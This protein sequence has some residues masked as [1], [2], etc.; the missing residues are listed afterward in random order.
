MIQLFSGI[1]ATLLLGVFIIMCLWKPIYLDRLIC[2]WHFRKLL[3]LVP[4]IVSVP[5]ALSLLSQIIGI[6]ASEMMGDG[7]AD[8]DRVGNA[9]VVVYHYLNS[10]FMPSASTDAGRWWALI[11]ALLGTVFMSGIL[12]SVLTSIFDT[13]IEAWKNGELRYHRG[14][15]DHIVIVGGNEL[16][17]PVIKQTFTKYNGEQYPH[18]WQILQRPLIIVQTDGDVEELRKT[19][20]KELPSIIENCITIYSGGRS[21][22]EE[23]ADLCL[24]KA[25]EIFVLG[26]STMRG[27]AELHHDSLN[28]QCT[29][30]IATLLDARNHK[31][32][33]PCHV[34]FDYH[35]TY[36]VFQFSDLPPVIKDNV[37]FLPFNIT[38][39]WAQ[40]VLVDCKDENII[41]NPLDGEGISEDSEKYVHLVIVGM[42]RMGIAMATQAAHI[43][44]YANFET[45]G[46]RTKISFIDANAKEEMD[47]FMNR[48]HY[49]FELCRHRYISELEDKG[50]SDP[51]AETK[52]F[53]HLGKNFIDIEWEFVDSNI[54]SA[55]AQVYL[56]NA[57]DDE[58]AIL[59]VAICLPEAQRAV[60]TSLYL[61]DSIY[62]TASQVLV[63]QTQVPSILNNVAHY[64]EGG[65]TQSQMRYRN[66]R[67]FGM[68]SSSAKDD[69]KK[70]RQALMVNAQYCGIDL[71]AKEAETEWRNLDVAL[72]WSCYYNVNSWATKM[73]STGISLNSDISVLSKTIETQ[74]EKLMKIEHNRW[75]VEKLLMGFRPLTDYEY[76]SLMQMSADEQ[77]DEKKRLKKI[78]HAHLNICSFEELYNSDP[79]SIKYDEDLVRA[80]PAILKLSEA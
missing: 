59:T 13:H 9:W 37:T 5:F 62:E 15:K 31:E 65:L 52:T 24:D 28:M 48:Y 34:L 39:N 16:V 30:V 12:I 76:K 53:S 80:I 41:Y 26:E 32:L 22:S 11:I 60:A 19:L 20:R 3:I 56:R 25:K 68:L 7:D 42:S 23:L 74:M 40:K 66:I 1:L 71:S 58:N 36:S 14:V 6:N 18:W 67:P 4:L 73:R 21:D 63:Y 17:V 35:E 46:K 70:R 47:K 69:E 57:L 72:K 78:C 33:V 79:G 55:F 2:R 45:K 64:A 75:V 49:L 61:P 54:E 51:M 29:E 43:C 44:H 38:D 8:M 50:W 77:K 10:G 27:N